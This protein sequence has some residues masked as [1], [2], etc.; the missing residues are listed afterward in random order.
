MMKWMVKQVNQKNKGFTLIEMVVV[1]AIIA[2]LIAIA[3]PQVMKQ[4]NKSKINA[5]IANAKAIATAIQQW[6]AEGNSLTNQSNWVAI[7]N[8][9]P[10]TSG[11]DQYITGGVPVPKLQNNT[12]F[13]YKYDSSTQTVFIGVYQG[14]FGT[15]GVELYPTPDLNNYK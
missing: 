2:V 8:N 9:V 1:L 14:S 12:K 3:V 13:A 7:E 5:D 10:I 11:L 6:V 4:I 15:N